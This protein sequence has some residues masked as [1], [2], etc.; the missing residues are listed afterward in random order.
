MSTY[1]YINDADFGPEFLKV[2]S[3][4]PWGTKLFLNGHEWAKRQLANKRIAY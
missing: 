2:C 1:F 4:S 3:Y